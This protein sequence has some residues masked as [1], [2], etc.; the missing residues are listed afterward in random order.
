MIASYD[1]DDI[2]ITLYNI[3][4]MIYGWADWTPCNTIHF[5]WKQNIKFAFAITSKP[6]WPTVKSL[7]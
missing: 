7:I 2:L 6:N 1:I 5:W 3:D 4:I